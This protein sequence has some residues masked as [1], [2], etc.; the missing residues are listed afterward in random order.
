MRGTK[1]KLSFTA[2]INFE[3][4]QTI[5]EGTRSTG[6]DGLG[7]IRGLIVIQQ[8]SAL[9][10]CCLLSRRHS[11]VHSR[12]GD[13]PAKLSTFPTDALGFEVQMC[14]VDKSNYWR[15]L[16]PLTETGSRLQ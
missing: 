13:E 10:L 12:G 15:R 11:L 5:W 16:V 1:A 6:L 4:I 8:L 14:T 9:S 3:G 7:Q 2:I